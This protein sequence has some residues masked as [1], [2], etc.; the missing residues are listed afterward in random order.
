MHTSSGKLSLR[1]LHL[2]WW[3]AQPATMI[4]ILRRAGVPKQVCDLIPETVS[5]C[6][7]CRAW[8]RPLPA[9]VASVELADTFNQQVECDLMFVLSFIIF[10]LIDRL[11][12]LA[13]SMFG[14]HQRR[15]SSHRC[16]GF[17][18]GQYSRTNARTYYGW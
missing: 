3:H 18:L 13:C 7:S 16:V 8:S 15:K 4:R 17:T 14:H 6:T 10:H 9:S 11:H 5:T 1:K 2:R 12:S